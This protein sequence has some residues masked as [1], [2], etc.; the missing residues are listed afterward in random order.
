MG[1]KIHTP[2]GGWYHATKFALAALSDCLPLEV[3]P[4]GINVV[5]IGPGASGPNGPGI[6][7]GKQLRPADPEPMRP[8]R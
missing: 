1:G 8:S 7:A 5:V 3:K 2:L 6:A 4:F